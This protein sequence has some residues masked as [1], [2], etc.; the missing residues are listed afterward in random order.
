MDYNVAIFGSQ[1]AV[2]TALINGLKERQFPVAG[3][4]L[5][6][7][8]DIGQE[9]DFN[10]KKVKVEEFSESTFNDIDLVFVAVK[11]ELSLKYSPVFVKKG[12][13]VVDN[14]SAYRMME[15]IPLVIP[16]VNPE[17]LANHQGIIANPNC[18]TTIAMVP[19]GAL[20]KQVKIKKV[21]AST[22]QA[23]SGGG[24]PGMNELTNQAKD[25]F[26]GE[27]PV[28]Q[29]FQHQ[30]AFNLIPHIEVFQDNG[31][32]KEEMKMHYEGR[33]ILESED[34]SVS[35]TCVRVPVYRSHS[36]SLTVQFDG[37]M[38]ADR[39]REI[40]KKAPGVLLVDDPQNNIYP[41]PIH[42]SNQDKVLVGR[43]RNDLSLDHAISLWV[44]GDQIRKGAATNAIQI[45]EELIR[46]ELV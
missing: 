2:G 16:E 11:N 33:K 27:E 30:I 17:A 4:R 18:S 26:N 46:R 23:V 39:A 5:F 38:D 14:S 22:Y 13:T 35:C 7:V 20:N 12:A 10:G 6:D 9:I 44:S 3:L 31:Y 1:G 40:L 15:D 25:I 8:V 34:M 24:E 32:T 43:I 37:E 45:A 19:L 36:I 29:I 21:I 41:M 42:A 28:S